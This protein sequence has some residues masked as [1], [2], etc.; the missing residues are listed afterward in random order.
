MNALDHPLTQDY[1]RRL[2]L[3]TVRLPVP[4]GRE[5]ED[6]IR[7]HLTEALGPQA[8]EAQIRETL[9]RLGDPAVLVDAAGGAPAGPGPGG[10][11]PATPV[12]SSA[13]REVGA[14]VLL[15]AAA[16]MFWFFPLNLV[17][18]LAGLVLLVLA[19]RWSVGEKVWGGLVLGLSWLVPLVLSSVAVAVTLEECTGGSSEPLTCSGGDGGLSA[20]NIASIVLTVG[21]LVTYVWTLV[22]LARSAARPT[23]GA[24]V[25]G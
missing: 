5:L 12:D 16:L 20:L 13:W 3:E 6:Q 24:S 19:R 2:H 17:L 8:S 11:Y 21:W 10:S 1:L 14:L 9:D 15:V 22:R 4:E 25:D 23:G 7:E 18:W